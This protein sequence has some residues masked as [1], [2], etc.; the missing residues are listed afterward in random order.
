MTQDINED[1]E[2]RKAMELS[3]IT[4]K[5]DAVRRQNRN[6]LFDQSFPINFDFPDDKI[7]RLRPKGNRYSDNI[8]YFSL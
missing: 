1:E 2:L 5:E 4:E 7:L 3:L 8:S 6:F